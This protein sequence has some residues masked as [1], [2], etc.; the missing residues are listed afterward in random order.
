MGQSEPSEKSSTFFSRLRES[1]TKE[2]IVGGI[3]ALIAGA[4]ATVWFVIGPD[5][6]DT[7]N[8]LRRAFE[9]LV[10]DQM[11][12]TELR[13]KGIEWSNTKYFQFPDNGGLWATII[14]NEFKE[15]N[16]DGRR[17]TVAI[18]I[19]E[20][21]SITEYIFS[22]RTKTKTASLIASAGYADAFPF[23]KFANVERLHF[24]R[25]ATDILLI[26]GTWTSATTIYAGMV[27]AQRRD[28][29]WTLMKCEVPGYLEAE[30]NKVGT[31]RDSFPLGLRTMSFPGRYS[32]NSF[33]MDML[34]FAN[35]DTRTDSQG[36]TQLIEITAIRGQQDDRKFGMVVWWV[37]ADG[38]QLDGQW[39]SGKP[40]L[41]SVGE[42]FGKARPAVSE[43]TDRMYKRGVE[44][45][46][47]D[48]LGKRS[49]TQN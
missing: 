36:N 42:L 6:I 40:L 4:A 28:K 9:K 45:Y 41:T 47:R 7:N 25:E 20:K 11:P 13:D 19:E 43:I 2:L 49:T 34:S 38:C 8:E 24:K 12:E 5:E 17:S 37:T 16:K 1:I 23:F 3:V 18:F 32:N 27:V 33:R 30:F 21:A 46:D 15:D 22:K 29:H 35:F 10:F 44:N 31:Y 26:S 48:R 39:N 14:N